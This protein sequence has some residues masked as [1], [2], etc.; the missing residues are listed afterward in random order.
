MTRLDDP[1]RAALPL[2]PGLL[3]AALA[4]TSRI[5]DPLL[6]VVAPLAVVILLLLGQR[7]REPAGADLAIPAGP[8]AGLETD[9]A[10]KSF[11]DA[12]ATDLDAHAPRT[13]RILFSGGFSAGYLLTSLPPAPDTL[14]NRRPRDPARDPVLGGLEESDRWPAL[15]VLMHRVPDLSGRLQAAEGDSDLRLARAFDARGYLRVAERPEWSI[16]RSR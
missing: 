3:A 13:G 5:R 12:L 1:V 16:L 2:I 11:L 15:V 10:T 9:A 6:R 7:S 14:E 8:F 4:L